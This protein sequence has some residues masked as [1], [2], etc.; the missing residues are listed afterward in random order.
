MAVLFNRRSSPAG[1]HRVLGVKCGMDPVLHALAPLGLAAAR[2]T[3]LVIDLDRGAP[4]YP[5][6]TSLAALV[7]SQPRLDDLRPRRAGVAVLPNGLASPRETADVVEAL[8]SGWPTVVFR[9]GT[10]ADLPPSL[11]ETPMITVSP[12]LPGFL[13]PTATGPAVYQAMSP[14]PPPPVRGIVLPPLGRSHIYR[15]LGGRG[16]PP[17]RWVQAWQKVWSLPWR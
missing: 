11:E 7:A 16:F 2:G 10:A 1:R 17:R 6:S 5:G 9:L 14:G 12:L 4:S 8:V 15:M 3:A 13:F